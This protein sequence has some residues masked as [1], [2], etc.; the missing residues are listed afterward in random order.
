MS[1]KDVVGGGDVK[2][3]AACLNTERTGGINGNTG[4]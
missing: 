4:G 3:A 1:S 2:K